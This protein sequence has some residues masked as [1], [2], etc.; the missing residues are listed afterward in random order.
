MR[1]IFSSWDNN[2]NYQTNIKTLR[3]QERLYMSMQHTLKFGV[4]N[5]TAFQYIN[6]SD[7]NATEIKENIVML[8]MCLPF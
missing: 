5:Q 2:L 1:F 4:G 8:I 6:L 3:L 7:T